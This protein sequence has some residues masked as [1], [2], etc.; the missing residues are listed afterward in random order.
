MGLQ[1]LSILALSVVATALILFF[2][3]FRRW[4]RGFIIAPFGAF[5]LYLLFIGTLF[6]GG[7]R[8]AG[9]ELLDPLR[10]ARIVLFSTIT[11]FAWLDLIL[12]KRKRAPIN[13]VVWIM[14]AYGAMAMATAS[15]SLDP[16][17]TLWKGFE[18][19]THVSVVAVLCRR[20]GS[21]DD[22]LD[23][24]G[25][26]WIVLLFIAISLLVA[27]PISPE[28]AFSETSKGIALLHG[29]AFTVNPNTGTQIGGLILLVAVSLLIASPPGSNKWIV[30]ALFILGAVVMLL[31]H[32]RT[33]IFATAIALCMLAVV[34]RK[35]WIIVSIF[36]LGLLFFVSGYVSEYATTFILRGQSEAQFTGL[37]GRLQ[38]WQTVW[39]TFVER[40]ILGYGFYAAIRSL[41]GVPGADNTYLQVLMGGGV[42]LLSVFL[43]AICVLAIQLFRTRPRWQTLR[44]QPAYF[45]LWTQTAS[46]FILLLI[47]SITGPSFDAHHINLTLFLVCAVAASALVRYRPRVRAQ[48]DTQQTAPA[49]PDHSSVNS[50]ARYQSRINSSR[51]S[52]R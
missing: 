49:D 19:L 36:T 44:G 11:G 37:S 25:L 48:S 51:P 24:L 17:L 50:P 47:R 42:V 5:L 2:Q 38:F 7:E 18:V 23:I 33:S 13:T 20:I 40:P 43:L 52:H 32:S 6:L 21:V 27:I 39:G 15:Y 31:T 35:A 1:S 14:F 8:T 16:K 46:L 41:Y 34:S 10:L 9:S 28:I 22:A 12:T 26:F 4:R 3:P 45:L 30:F 29:V